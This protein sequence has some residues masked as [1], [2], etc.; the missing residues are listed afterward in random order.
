MKLHLLLADTHRRDPK[1]T[2]PMNTLFLQL[3]LFT[4]LLSYTTSQTSS[5]SSPSR[6]VLENCLPL[7]SSTNTI[8]PCFTSFN[9]LDPFPDC[10][11]PEISELDNTVDARV[12]TEI[13]RANLESFLRIGRT[14]RREL[15]AH[16][17]RRS[18]R[19]RQRHPNNI[20]NHHNHHNQDYLSPNLI[21]LV[22]DGSCTNSVQ[23]GTHG[24][25]TIGRNI[26]RPWSSN[27]LSVLKQLDIVVIYEKYWNEMNETMKQRSLTTLGKF[28]SDINH[29][30]NNGSGGNGRVVIVGIDS[31]KKS[32]GKDTVSMAPSSP[33]KWFQDHS[34][35][36][37]AHEITLQH[38][39]AEA[40]EMLL[41][42]FIDRDDVSNMD[43]KTIPT[44][45]RFSRPTS[46]SSL[47]PS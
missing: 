30:N 10:L 20:D 7:Q 27:D 36:H 3:L 22:L 47:C 14:R 2:H 29:S 15:M 46:S 25:L 18:T 43:S 8:I 19:H 21:K 37:T 11:I 17:A 32:D 12:V 23:V 35:Y 4:N 13:T 40:A 45:G 24:W 28:M 34:L 41:G 1:R 16:V 38:L 44:L 26:L 6:P 42:L 31:Q 5:N 33:L 9:S 39:T